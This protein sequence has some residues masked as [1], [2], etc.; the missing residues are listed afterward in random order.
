MYENRHSVITQVQSRE[1]LYYLFV[2]RRFKPANSNA[3][4]PRLIERY[5]NWSFCTAITTVA[6]MQFISAAFLCFLMFQSG[7]AIPSNSSGITTDLRK[8]N[9]DGDD[10]GGGGGGTNVQNSD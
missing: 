9:P 4:G 6:Q 2:E 1:R 8:A 7:L 3:T 5:I 10:G